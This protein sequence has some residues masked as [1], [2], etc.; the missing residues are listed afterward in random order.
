MSFQRERPTFVHETCYVNTRVEW[1]VNGDVHRPAKGVLP[2]G[3]I[4]YFTDCLYFSLS[5]VFS[6]TCSW[7]HLVPSECRRYGTK[8]TFS[9]FDS[10]LQLH[11][12]IRILHYKYAWAI[13]VEVVKLFT[14]FIHFLSLFFFWQVLL[15]YLP[16]KWKNNF[17]K[18][19]DYVK[20][21]L[22]LG[23]QIFYSLLG[24]LL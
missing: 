23:L 9:I 1:Q 12:Q 13:Y 3:V 14:H 19:S 2:L 24:N 16:I 8:K 7:R 11:S 17:I 5:T 22:L 4:I 18:S 15:N 21:I 6:S 20:F 10:N